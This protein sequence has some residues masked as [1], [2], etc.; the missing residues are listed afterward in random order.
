MDIMLVRKLGAPRQEELAMGAIAGGGGVVLNENIL[1][2]L[3]ISEKKLQDVINRERQELQRREAL[4]REGRPAMEI[5]G[6]AVVL[7]DDGLATGASM[8]AAIMAVK[9][10]ARRVVVAVPV[11]APGTCEELGREVDQVVCAVMP[12]RLDAVSMFYREFEPTPDDEV[13][14]LMRLGSEIGQ[15]NTQRDKIYSLFLRLSG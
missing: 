14:E 15:K 3:R 6:R 13:A 10:R 2:S 5:D 12:E 1:H 11:G 4:Y 7:V 9:A 8:R